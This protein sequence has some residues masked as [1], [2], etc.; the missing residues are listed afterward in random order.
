MSDSLSSFFGEPIFSYS[1]AQAI[2]DGVLIDIT[3][4]A[5]E[6]GFRFPT[7]IT[8]AVYAIVRDETSTSDSVDG[9]LWD[10]CSI[11][12]LAMK[13]AQRGQD[14]VN[15]NVIIGRRTQPLYIQIGPGDTPAP[16]LTIMMQ[17][18]D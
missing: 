9:R 15:F 12:M 4:M 3:K 6:A 2:E 17:G 16:V 13:G 8:A 5:K 14:R 11:A 7:V 18:E 10:I 1:R